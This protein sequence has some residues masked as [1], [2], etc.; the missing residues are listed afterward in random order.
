MDDQT[1]I[2][3]DERA[4]RAREARHARQQERRAA[5]IMGVFVLRAPPPAHGFRW[6]I[7]RFGTIV[8]RAG[9]NAY[10]TP[11]AAQAAGETV[12]ALWPD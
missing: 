10:A 5:S 2:V 4:T 6:E 1:I 7:R 11:A 3:L 9:E 12:R 8:L